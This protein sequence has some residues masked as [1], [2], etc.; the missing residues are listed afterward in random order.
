MDDTTVLKVHASRPGRAPIARAAAVIGRGGLV[1]FPTE[2]VYGLGADGLSEEAVRRI[3]VAKGRPATSPLILHVTALDEVEGLAAAIPDE[4]RVLAARFWPGPLTLVLHRTARVPDAVAAGGATFS[5]RAPAHPVAIALIRACARP[6]AAPSANL[7]GRP[8]P[9]TAAHVLDDLGGRV[10][11][12]LDAG[13]TPLGIESTV[14]DLTV[15]PARILRP[16]ALTRAEIEDVIGPVVSAGRPEVG[17]DHYRPRVPVHLVL[18]GDAAPRT[19]ARLVEELGT[20]KTR[21]AGVGVILTA[22]T[23]AARGGRWPS[24]AEVRVAG[25]AEAPREIGASLYNLLRELEGC[26]VTAIV[27]EGLA[28]G[29]LSAVIMDR[30]RE[31]AGPRVYRA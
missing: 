22:E 12:V 4:A 14:L 10:D 18:A 5:C 13:S 1:A 6:L 21:G 2:T 17:R 3:F 8:S 7:S 27:V 31:A 29:G 25:R 11:L 19:I 15:R 24:G 9:V 26:G 30:L 23:A 16:G 28:G 20:G